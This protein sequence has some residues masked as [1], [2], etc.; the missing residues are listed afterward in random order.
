MSLAV[1]KRVTAEEVS[2]WFAEF[3][4]PW[5]DN[6]SCEEIA[7]RL[8]RMLKLE[9]PSP[10]YLEFQKYRES[11]NLKSEV[12]S[13]GIPSWDYGLVLKSA[14]VLQNHIPIMLRNWEMM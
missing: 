4:R 8:N 13:E 14:K 10:E 5:P 1:P 3:R 6:D 7:F 2:G 9:P 11:E 12:S